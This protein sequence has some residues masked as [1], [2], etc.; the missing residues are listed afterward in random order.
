[1]GLYF[2]V[3]A[4]TARL[5]LGF[6]F[7]ERYLAVRPKGQQIGY[8]TVYCITSIIQHVNFL[9]LL[10]NFEEQ[11]EVFFNVTS[12]SLVKQLGHPAKTSQSHLAQVLQR[13][14]NIEVI[15]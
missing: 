9:K 8:C 4:C 14:K 5:Q 10:K 6:L 1:M 13:L 3:R 7:Q 11:A 2:Q 15:P 12:D